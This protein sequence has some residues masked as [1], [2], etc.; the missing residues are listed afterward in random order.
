M[1]AVKL[2]NKIIINLFQI[3]IHMIVEILILKY[4]I[5]DT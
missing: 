3:S 4:L 1:L 2:L 5:F